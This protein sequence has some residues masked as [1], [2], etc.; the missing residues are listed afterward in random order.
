M[1]VSETCPMRSNFRDKEG[2]L[3]C[4][5]FERK[6]EV[7]VADPGSNTAG[8]DQPCFPSHR[9]FVTAAVPTPELFC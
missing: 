5:D 1:V 7:T 8:F 6:A 4:R 2:P 9:M 3:W